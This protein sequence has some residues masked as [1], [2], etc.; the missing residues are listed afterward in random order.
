MKKIL[1]LLI[2][3]LTPH[4]PCTA[5]VKKDHRAIVNKAL[6]KKSFEIKFLYT[7]YD[8][9][10]SSNLYSSATT[11]YVY[12]KM[13][14]IE[15]TDSLIICD[16]K[17]AWTYLPKENEVHIT[18]AT[19]HPNLWNLLSVYSKFYSID[20]VREVFDEKEKYFLATLLAKDADN[21]YKKLVLK[22]NSKTNILEQIHIYESEDMLHIFEIAYMKDLENSEKSFFTF[23]IE[24]YKNLEIID[25]R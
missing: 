10:T 11:I 20:T 19:D 2:I 1:F 7:A 8:L 21:D 6:S 3:I 18:K 23:S 16:G 22:I 24:K 4:T 15:N 12:D 13:Y 14:Y 17:T 5:N 25:L 9:N